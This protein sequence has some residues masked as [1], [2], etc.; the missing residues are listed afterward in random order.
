MKAAADNLHA[1]IESFNEIKKDCIQEKS[2]YIVAHSMGGLV[3]RA[4]CQL[5]GSKKY[6]SKIVTLGTPHDGTLYDAQVIGHMIHWGESIS[7]KMK[8][9]T[10]NA[11]SAKEL[12]KKD[13]T[14]GQCLIDKL[15]R[16]SDSLKDIKIFSV[17]G[18]KK[19]LDYGSFFKSYIAN[20]KIQKWFEDKPNDGLVLEYSSNI[21]N[22]TPDADNNHHHFN[23]YTEYD[24]INHSYLIDNHQILLKLTAWLKE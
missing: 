17:S 11:N 15:Q 3:A 6:V 20:W 8:G 4:L 5:T 13:N 19:W 2:L 9:F 7:S 22:S 14:N 23:K 1:I 16:D 12:T 10:P 24:D 21:K 18:G